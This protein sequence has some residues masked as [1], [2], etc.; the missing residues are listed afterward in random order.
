MRASVNPVAKEDWCP[1]V[2]CSRTPK[3]KFVSHSSATQKNTIA[4]HLLM[5]AQEVGNA[6]DQPEGRYG[7]IARP[8]VM[9]VSSGCT[10]LATGLESCLEERRGQQGGRL[11]GRLFNQALRRMGNDHLMGTCLLLFSFAIT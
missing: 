2:P 9:T 1:N 6:A 5:I 3:E 4:R 11:G 7:N 10:A 8:G